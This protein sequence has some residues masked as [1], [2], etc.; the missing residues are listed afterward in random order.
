MGT[1]QEPLGTIRQSKAVVIGSGISGLF[2]ALKLAESGVKT[3]LITKSSVHENNSRYAQGGIAAVLPSNP[4]DSIEL[5]IQDTINASSGLCD[6]TAVRSILSDGYESIMDLIAH[7]VRFDK[8]DD[9]DLAMTREAAHSVNRI[10]HAAGDA[11]GFSVEMTLIERVRTHDNIEVIEYGFVTELLTQQGACVGCRVSLLEEK[12]TIT[13]Y[14][15]HVVLATGGLGR[16]YSHTTNPSI[17]TGDGFALAHRC[18]AKLKHMEFVQFHPTAFFHD[19]Q[20]RFLISEALRGEG[21]LLKNKNGDAFA[22]SFHPDGELAPRDVVTR[23]I[24]EEMQSSGLPYVYLDISHL[25]TEKIEARFPTIMKNCLE[26]DIDI[27]TDWIPVAPAAH[28]MMG[29]V[30]VDYLTGQ[31]DVTGLYAVGETACTGLH[32]ANRLASNSLLECVVL[33]RRVAECIANQEERPL[34]ETLYEDET[35][36]QFESRRDIEQGIGALHQ[37]MWTNVGIVR[38]ENGLKRALMEIEAL[39]HKAKQRNWQQFAPE[40]VELCNQLHLAKLMTESAL[41]RTVSLGAHYRS[42]VL[43]P[44]TS[45]I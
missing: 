29:G 3:I 39:T 15:P 38:E 24:Y 44:V 12:S 16:M 32:G 30:V 26:Y 6:E 41:N 42:D 21:G 11:T 36:L 45:N 8:T 20:L 27:R 14:S 28:Y 4:N 25:P 34:P 22:Q 19:N 1:S 2:T 13:I 37:L 31:T 43:N 7:G 10:L 17:A 9:D 23:G 18:G 35:P 33:A 5:H 40:G